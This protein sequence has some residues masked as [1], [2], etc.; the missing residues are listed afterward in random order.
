MTFSIW[1]NSLDFIVAKCMNGALKGKFHK[2]L[3]CRIRPRGLSDD[4]WQIWLGTLRPSALY[5]WQGCWRNTCVKHPHQSLSV[6]VW[7]ADDSGVAVMVTTEVALP[8][9]HICW[10]WEAKGTCGDSWWGVLAQQPTAAL[11]IWVK[12]LNIPNTNLSSNLLFLGQWRFSHSSWAGHVAHPL[13]MLQKRAW[14]MAHSRCLSGRKAHSHLF[15][16]CG[17]ALTCKQGQGSLLPC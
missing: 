14:A 6:S 11:N 9:C 16:A 15:P 12:A 5:L 1:G 8:S 7:T 2:V 3:E 13:G 10:R 17:L 4:F